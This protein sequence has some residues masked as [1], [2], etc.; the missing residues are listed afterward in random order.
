[1]FGLSKLFCRKPLDAAAC[2]RLLDHAEV[3][4]ETLLKLEAHLDGKKDTRGKAITARLHRQLW[5]VVTNEGPGAGMDVVAFSGGT[6]KD[7]QE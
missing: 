2:K 5:E 3:V 1:M 4:K 7:L 6:P